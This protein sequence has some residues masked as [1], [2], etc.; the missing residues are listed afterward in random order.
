MERL[1]DTHNRYPRTMQEAFGPYTNQ[2]L[3]PMATPTETRLV[4]VV[5]YLVSIAALAF[6]VFLVCTGR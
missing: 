3:T 4:D 6:V 1:N 5:V 2:Q